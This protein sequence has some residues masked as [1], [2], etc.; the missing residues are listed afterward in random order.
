MC[1]SDLLSPVIHLD[2]EPVLAFR[3]AKRLWAVTLV[4]RTGD[5]VNN[6]KENRDSIAK[7]REVA[8]HNRWEASKW[9][10]ELFGEDKGDVN[11]NVTNI[12]ALHVDALRHRIVEASP[13]L[14][15]ELQRTDAAVPI[16][17]AIT[18]APLAVPEPVPGRGGVVER[19]GVDGDADAGTLWCHDCRRNDC[20]HVKHEYARQAQAYAAQSPKPRHIAWLG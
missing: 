2:A 14:A 1:S 18:A 4:E 16:G 11:V 12:A 19:H 10:R 3:E 15:E 8:A 13:P 7:V 6:V 17:D 20:R 9:D 5:L